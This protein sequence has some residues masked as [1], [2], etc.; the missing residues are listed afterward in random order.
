MPK[1]PHTEIGAGRHGNWDGS[2]AYRKKRAEEGRFHIHAAP[3][4]LFYQHLQVL[5]NQDSEALRVKRA[6]QKVDLGSPGGSRGGSPA[7]LQEE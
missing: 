5:G 1:V 2:G 6:P 4:L 3:M 7:K